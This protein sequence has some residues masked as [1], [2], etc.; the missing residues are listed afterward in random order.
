MDRVMTILVFLYW[1]GII[2]NEGRTVSHM[3]VNLKAC[4]NNFLDSSGCITLNS[5]E[6]CTRFDYGTIGVF[7]QKFYIWPDDGNMIIL[8]NKIG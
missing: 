6:F 8:L 5:F 4:G 2:R 1:F 3:R 7:Q